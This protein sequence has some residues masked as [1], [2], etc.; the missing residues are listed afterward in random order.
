MSLLP[1][2]ERV[3]EREDLSSPDAQSAMLIILSGQATPPQIAAFLTAL[4]MKGE[5]VEELVGFA[6]GMREMATP[7]DAALHGETLLDTCGT[8]GGGPA[9]FNISTLV[10]FVVAGA[11]VRVAKHGN[12]SNSTPCGSA[13]L[14]EMMGIDIAFSASEAARAIRE[15][16]IG[17]LF[18]PGVHTAMKHAQ[19][20]RRDLKMRTVFNLL[21]PL[22]N[23]AGATS[24]LVGAPSPKAAQLMAG[25]LASLGLR[26]GFV[27]HGSDGLDEITTTGPT[28]AFEV[29]DGKVEQRELEPGDFGVGIAKAEDLAG[30]DK[31]RNLEIANAILSGERG[32]GR[33]IVLVNAAAALVVAGKVDTFLQGVAVAVVSIDSG[34]AR[35]KVEALARFTK[36][37]R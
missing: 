36:G 19:P 32:A 15:V 28:L 5:T 6:R 9:T 3:A 37:R 29:R 23:P 33:D 34:A 26:H 35:S 18:A 20:V 30:G 21:G 8:G 13:D 11:G 10:A 16:G 22:T 7:V 2:L 12:R 4:R 14:L 27:V 17:F 31:A 25:A 24:Q 1:Y